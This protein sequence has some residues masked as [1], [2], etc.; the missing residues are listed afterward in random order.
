VQTPFGSTV[1]WMPVGQAGSQA[2]QQ[3]GRPNN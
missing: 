2:P 1:R 3:T